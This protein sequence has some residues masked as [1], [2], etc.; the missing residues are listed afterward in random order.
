VMR[1]RKTSFPRV[2]IT[3]AEKGWGIPELR[4]IALHA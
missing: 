1:T 2:Y 3:S 4:A